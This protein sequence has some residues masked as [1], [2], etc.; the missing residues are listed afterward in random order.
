MGE[1][2]GKPGRECCQGAAPVCVGGGSSRRWGTVL[3]AKGTTSAKASGAARSGHMREVERSSQTPGLLPK[4]ASRRA[5]GSHRKSHVREGHGLYVRDPALAAGSG[6]TGTDKTEGPRCGVGAARAAGC[7]RPSPSYH[8]Q[9]CQTPAQN[10]PQE[11]IFCEVP[12][13]WNQA[14]QT[15]HS[16]DSVWKEVLASFQ[17]GWVGLR[18]VSCC[19]ETRAGAGRD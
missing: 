14:L 17:D 19:I 16:G 5:L 1:I 11:L 10:L 7:Y 4:G 8:S 12:A 15:G 9:M 2:P 6:G 13:F 18:E 3:L